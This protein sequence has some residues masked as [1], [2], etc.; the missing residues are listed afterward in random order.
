MA[1]GDVRHRRKMNKRKLRAQ[2]KVRIATLDADVAALKLTT[3]AL[4][5]R[6]HDSFPMH[7]PTGVLDGVVRHA[8]AVLAGGWSPAVA[9]TQ[10][11]FLAQL[12]RP[13][14]MFNGAVVGP[15][16]MIE[17]WKRCCQ[18]ARGFSLE[19]CALHVVAQRL[20]R[21]ELQVTLGAPR[22]TL[23]AMYPDAAT[24]LAT[25]PLFCTVCIADVPGAVRWTCHVSFDATFRV[26]RLEI[27]PQYAAALT[28]LSTNLEDVADVVEYLE[29]KARS[30][31]LQL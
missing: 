13:D 1:E 31:T 24:A 11:P 21:L 12:L 26:K 7:V 5:A 19:L 4:E 10:E 8:V 25:S 23:D 6:L 18:S 27:D 30:R 16:S 2:E 17:R 20:V 28:R 29:V 15:V 22:A 14:I 3:A 9:H